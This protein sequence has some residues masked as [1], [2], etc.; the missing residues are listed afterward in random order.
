MTVIIALI[1]EPLNNKKEHLMNDALYCFHAFIADFYEI[2][3]IHGALSAISP[4][5]LPFQRVGVRQ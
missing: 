1:V 4:P 2:L 5:S 3:S